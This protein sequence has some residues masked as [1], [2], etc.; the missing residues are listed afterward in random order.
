MD[1]YLFV[2]NYKPRP[3]VRDG[4]PLVVFTAKLID[5]TD[6]AE[7]QLEVVVYEVPSQPFRPILHAIGGQPWPAAGAQLEQETRRLVRMCDSEI[8]AAWAE[9]AAAVATGARDWTKPA[10]PRPPTALEL[11]R[12]ALQEQ[13]DIPLAKLPDDSREVACACGGVKLPWREL[14]QVCAGGRTAPG[15][16][17]GHLADPDLI[18]CTRAILAAFSALDSDGGRAVDRAN[19][20]GPLGSIG[21]AAEALQPEAWP[22]CFAF[23]GDGRMAWTLLSLGQ[24]LESVCGV[25]SQPPAGLEQ[26]VGPGAVPSL[27]KVFELAVYLRR[28]ASRRVAFQSAPGLV[29]LADATHA[30]WLRPVACA[31]FLAR[32]LDTQRPANAEGAE[33]VVRLAH[34]ALRAVIAAVELVPADGAELR[35][36]DPDTDD[37]P[38]PLATPAKPKAPRLGP[39]WT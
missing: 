38:V 13:L 9:A 24:S 7:R 2:P 16:T 28:Q 21:A 35:Q 29:C 15:P 5:R 30:P 4:A 14:C 18:V 17:G 27:R 12:R 6:Q 39:K 33:Q 10:P 36:V 37:P 23:Q 34:E 31:G 11:E 22:E 19:V 26:L 20:L 25:R 1:A 8:R 3:V 32:L